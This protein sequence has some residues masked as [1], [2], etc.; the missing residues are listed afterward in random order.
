MV[1]GG[2]VGADDGALL[3]LSVTLTWRSRDCRLWWTR[4]A[5]VKDTPH[6]ERRGQGSRGPGPVS[7]RTAITFCKMG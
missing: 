5:S 4:A 7:Q 3:D 6:G 2:D 1:G